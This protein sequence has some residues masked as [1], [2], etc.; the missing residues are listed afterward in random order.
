MNETPFYFHPAFIGL[1][2]TIFITGTSAIITF[3][4]WLIRQEAKILALT[5]KNLKLEKEVA[6]LW[7]E[8]ITHRERTDLHFNEA[9]TKQVD[10]ANDA[11]F[12]R[13][14]SDITEIKQMVK[15]LI[16]R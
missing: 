5:E 13:I 16:K 3:T 9:I 11:R 12:L 7:D 2:L 10:K 15:E 1:F 8:L 4:V 6:Q 14:E